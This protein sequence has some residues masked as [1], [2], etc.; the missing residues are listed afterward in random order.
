MKKHSN[1]CSPLS[2]FAPAEVFR[3]TSQEVFQLAIR[4][5]SNV[6]Y[7]GENAVRVIPSYS[8][9][10]GLTLLSQAAAELLGFSPPPPER[11][12]RR[13]HLRGKFKCERQGKGYKQP[14]ANSATSAVR[15][16]RNPNSQPG[17]VS[18]RTSFS[19][20][21]FCQRSVELASSAVWPPTRPC[22]QSCFQI[23]IASVGKSK[24]RQL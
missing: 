14:G 17:S 1:N 6:N 4:N 2:N 21:F 11:L 15:P 5:S 7:T 23:P 16:R 12:K 13:K 18:H 24:R 8:S 20:S 19:S 9:S 22:G 10:P 3:N